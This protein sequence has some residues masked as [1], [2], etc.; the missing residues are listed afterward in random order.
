LDSE[1]PGETPEAAA[2]MTEPNRVVPFTQEKIVRIIS[3][4]T[5]LAGVR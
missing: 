2:R 5:E 3:R 1:E 4:A